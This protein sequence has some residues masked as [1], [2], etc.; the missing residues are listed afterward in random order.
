MIGI[1]WYNTTSRCQHAK[2]A[3]YDGF[4]SKV[5]IDIPTAALKLRKLSDY[6]PKASH[7]YVVFYCTS[8]LL[9]LTS[10]REMVA[11]CGYHCAVCTSTCEAVHHE[12][13]QRH[14]HIKI[15]TEWL[16]VVF[17][18][19]AL[20]LKKKDGGRVCSLE[21]NGLFFCVLGKDCVNVY[22]CVLKLS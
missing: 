20:R 12:S 11:L 7:V 9:I 22:V 1:Y 14:P 5:Q 16:H 19:G 6:A 15:K 2:C 8:H 17:L 3:G 13:W 18:D 21:C 4:C 10:H